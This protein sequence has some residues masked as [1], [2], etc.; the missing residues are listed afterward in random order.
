MGIGYRA[1]RK[2]AKLAKQ[3]KLTNENL[4]TLKLRYLLKLGAVHEQELKFNLNKYR[5][6]LEKVIG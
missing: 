3:H 6:M 5:A 2:L 1:S 4:Y